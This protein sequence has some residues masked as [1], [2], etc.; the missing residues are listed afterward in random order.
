M[1][2]NPRGL[3]KY[4]LFVIFF[5]TSDIEKAVIEN[6]YKILHTIQTEYNVILTAFPQLSVEF[7]TPLISLIRRLI[8]FS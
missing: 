4:S 5:S 2:N 3:E 7:Y 8:S 1:W 6:L